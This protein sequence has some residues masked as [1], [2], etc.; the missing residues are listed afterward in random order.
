MRT[1]QA[2]T[3]ETRP[4]TTADRD[5]ETTTVTVRCTGHVRTA[6]GTHELEFTFEGDRLRD[7]LEDFFAEY[8][9]EDM[10]IAETE[11]D[12]THSGWA[13]VPDDLPGT[14]RKNP[15]GDQ[16][17]PYA[18]VCVN[19]RFNEHLGGFEAELEEDDRVAL[20]YPF[21]FCC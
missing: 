12:A 18:R 11:A 14:W 6:V 2:T 3:G 9:L 19:G 1:D 10:L 8:D 5:I 17:R 13:P 4:A 20:I 7:F 15:E 21:M 16:T